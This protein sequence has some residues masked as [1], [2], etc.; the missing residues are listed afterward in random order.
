[1][2]SDPNDGNY[3]YLDI[4]SDL[5]MKEN[6]RSEYIEE[7]YRLYNTYGNPPYITF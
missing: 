3:H 6:P 2:V 4:D 1:M 7:W 5:V